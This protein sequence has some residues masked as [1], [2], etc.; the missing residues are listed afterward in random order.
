MAVVELSGP[1]LQLL[2]DA[3]RL[4]GE[5]FADP[6]HAQVRDPLVSKLHGALWPDED[7]VSDESTDA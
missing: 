6:L 7:A 4:S 2:L 3:L 1:E 5:A